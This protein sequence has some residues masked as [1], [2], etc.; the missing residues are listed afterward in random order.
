MLCCVTKLQTLRFPNFSTNVALS[1]I[2]APASGEFRAA[3]FSMTFCDASSQATWG[4]YTT[5]LTCPKHGDQLATI[6]KH[7]T[8]TIQHGTVMELVNQ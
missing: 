5:L 7:D 2:S 1:A 4:R 8:G 3:I 6:T